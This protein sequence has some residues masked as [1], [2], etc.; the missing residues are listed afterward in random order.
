MSIVRTSAFLLAKGEVIVWN[1][2]VLIL[3]MLD[4]TRS[5]DDKLDCV[6]L[7]HY[8]RN[9]SFLFLPSVADSNVDEK[10]LNGSGN[11]RT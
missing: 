3:S 7:E 2:K 4:R 10:H 5:C 8:A 11:L 9:V 1:I 6:Q